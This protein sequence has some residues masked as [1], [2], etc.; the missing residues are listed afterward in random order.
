MGNHVD[1]VEIDGAS[2][3]GIDDARRLLEAGD[4]A[5]V[6]VPSVNRFGIVEDLSGFA[7]ASHDQKAQMM[8]YADP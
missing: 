8:V 3:R 7:E 4:V 1:V 5:G 6:L 2:N